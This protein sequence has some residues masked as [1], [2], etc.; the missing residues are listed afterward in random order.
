MPTAGV[1]GKEVTAE[2]V[3]DSERGSMKISEFVKRIQDLQELVGD[4]EVIIKPF[5][6]E[7]PYEVA[8][9][10]CINVVEGKGD[11]GETRWV[12][13]FDPDNADVITLVH[14]F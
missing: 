6:D 9:V 3:F 14:V 10:E 12:D 7:H 1:G 4:V 13:H 11:D 8:A 2:L 5:Y